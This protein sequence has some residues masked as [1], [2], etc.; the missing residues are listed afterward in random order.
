MSPT[1]RIFYNGASPGIKGKGLVYCYYRLTDDFQR[2]LELM[3]SMPNKFFVPTLD[4]DLA[5][6]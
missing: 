6:Q 1:I 2:F 3:S 4:I 5:W